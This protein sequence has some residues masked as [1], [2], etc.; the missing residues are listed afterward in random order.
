[1]GHQGFC[2]LFPSFYVCANT[3]TKSGFFLNT[4]EQFTCMFEAVAAHV[5]AKTT[6]T[7]KKALAKPIEW[8]VDNFVW[9]KE[10]M[11]CAYTHTYTYTYSWNGT[12]TTRKMFERTNVYSHSQFTH[13]IHCNNT[14]VSVIEMHL[15]NH[16]TCIRWNKNRQSTQTPPNCTQSTHALT[17]THPPKKEGN[18]ENKKRALSP[19]LQ[20]TIVPTAGW[21]DVYSCKLIRNAHCTSR[22]GC[23]CVCICV[24]FVLSTKLQ[25]NAT[26]AF[27]LSILMV[28]F[29]HFWAAIFIFIVGCIQ[30][31]YYRW[32]Q[33]TIV[34][35]AINPLSLS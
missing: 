29:F 18:I 31:Q 1:M 5:G 24:R 28:F 9:K 32:H 11:H 17:C 26:K 8:V 6:T 35:N 27:T 22:C 25:Q 2:L 15:A 13:S 12:K 10:R 20:S 19:S 16:F 14:C 30:F 33:G 4:I 3:K 21:G 7:N 23:V 34:V